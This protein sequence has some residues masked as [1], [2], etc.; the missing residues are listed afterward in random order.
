MLAIQNAALPDQNEPLELRGIT[1]IKKIKYIGPQLTIVNCPNLTLL[2]ISAD[3]VILKNIG[4][5]CV[6]VGEC[7]EM[8][9]HNSSVTLQ[10]VIDNRLIAQNCRGVI[11]CQNTE[12]VNFE[13]CE[14]VNINNCTMVQIGNCRHV[15]AIKTNSSQIMGTFKTVYF[16]DIANFSAQFGK[17][18][19][20]EMINCREFF[21]A[22][23]KIGRLEIKN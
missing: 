7:S 6:I 11:Q 5:N 23:F 17:A 18:D 13:D 9:I 1:G 8:T 10:C 21:S 15:R 19:R 20:M 12:Y 3:K 14:S 2:D 4:N 22:E 16:D